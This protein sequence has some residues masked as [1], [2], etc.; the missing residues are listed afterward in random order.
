MRQ[1][2]LTLL[3]AF[4]VTV[5]AGEQPLPAFATDKARALLAYL[6]LQPAQAHRRE[7][8]AALFWPEISQS[9]ALTN[10]RQTFHRLRAG[11]DRASP[12]CSDSL[13]LITR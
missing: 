7:L 5:P 1:I 12:G 4:A 3:G 9:A 11:L 8:L 6:A 2:L 10:L 13:F